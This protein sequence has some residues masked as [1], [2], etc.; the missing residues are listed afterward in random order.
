M[1]FTY[2]SICEVRNAVF[3]FHHECKVFS[4]P[5]MPVCIFG[6]EH[7][8]HR[9]IFQQCC[10]HHTFEPLAPRWRVWMDTSAEPNI[11]GSLPSACPSLSSHFLSCVLSDGLTLGSAK[12]TTSLLSSIV[13][14]LSLLLVH[15]SLPAHSVAPLS[16]THPRLCQP[17]E[18]VCQITCVDDTC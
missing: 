7:N 10:C 15:S 8:E 14:H 4:M 18:Y 13:W 5:K 16:Q 2:S 17:F 9:F 1:C 11:L 12:V 6:P 3:L